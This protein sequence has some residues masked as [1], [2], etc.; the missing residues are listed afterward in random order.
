MHQRNWCERL[1]FI[2][3]S[4]PKRN[5]VFRTYA[6]IKPGNQCG[7][8]LNAILEFFELPCDSQKSVPLQFLNI[9]NSMSLSK[10]IE[11][12]TIAPWKTTEISFELFRMSS[13]R[14]LNVAPASNFDL[15]QVCNAFN[16][17][18]YISFKN[19]ADG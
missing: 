18:R 12:V 13:T 15:S 2:P 8:I 3:V 7:F 10:I 11:P 4:F 14:S 17:L 6:L 9:E 1:Q 19:I 16:N 5:E